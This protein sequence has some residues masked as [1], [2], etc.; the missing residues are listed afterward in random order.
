[1][2]EPITTVDPRI[3]G[4]EAPTGNAVP[5]FD[6]MG[7]APAL[8]QAAPAPDKVS[9]DLIG[10]GTQS[11]VVGQN[12][13]QQNARE[14]S[15]VGT[16]LMASVKT[17]SP[18]R[19]WDYVN[20]P[21]FDAD[22]DFDVKPYVNA[23]K[24]VMSED[25]QK[26]LAQSQSV[27]EFNYRQQ[28]TEQQR[29]LYQQMGDHPIL[30]TLTG[31]ADPGYLALDL[32]TMGVAGSAAGL[33]GAGR[34]AQR[35][36]AGVATA[37]TTYGLGRIQQDVV[38]MSE[39]DVILPALMTGAAGAMF[40]RAGKGLV[41]A[42]PDYPVEDLSR[43]TA[44]VQ[45]QNVGV[46][47]RIVAEQ[48][49]AAFTRP[50][51][52]E[53]PVA[54]VAEPAVAPEVI[55]N[56]GEP[57]TPTT[58]TPETVTPVVLPDDTVPVRRVVAGESSDAALARRGVTP[59][60]IA[61]GT[62]AY[63][64]LGQYEN[65]P[66]YGTM[67]RTL[68]QEQ[69]DLLSSLKAVESQ[70]LGDMDQAFY[71]HN[72]H[73]M[74]VGKGDGVKQPAF[75]ALHEAVHGLTAAKIEY[76][77]ANPGSAHGSLVQQL[78]RLRL[79]AKRAI[80]DTKGTLS[81]NEGYLQDYYTKN[82]H[83]FAAGLFSGTGPMGGG[84]VKALS[85]MSVDGAP[86]MLSR[87]TNTVRKL[88]G[89]PPNQQSVLT[90][91]LGLTDDL[92]NTKLDLQIHGEVPG[93]RRTIEPLSTINLAPKGTPSQQAATIINRQESAA[94]KVG[95]KISWSLHKTMAGLSSEGKRVADTLVDDPVNMT[96]DSVVS[97]KTAIRSDL[98]QK[99]YVYEDQLKAEMAKRGA[100]IKNRLIHP[101]N[102]AQI[103]RQVEREVYDELMRRNNVVRRGGNMNDP[104][105]NQ[106]IAKMA[107]AHDAATSAALREMKSAGVMGADVIDE[108]AGYTPR[109]WSVTQIESVEG[110]MQ[111]AGSTEKEARAQ[112]RKLV[113][114]A[115]SRANP[116]WEPQVV[117]DVSAAILD[118]ARRKGYFEDQALRGHAGD[119]AAKE[120]RDILT[121][122]G[123]SKDRIDKAL[124]VI[125]GVN[126]EAGK[127]A[128]LKHRIDMDTTTTTRLQDGTTASVTDLL[129]TNVARNL[130]GYLDNAA[131]NAALARKGLGDT[132]SIAKLRTD[133]LHGVSNEGKRKEAAGLFDN[134]IASIKG[135][136]VGEEMNDGM[137]KLA[138]VTQMVGLSSSG[139]WQVTEYANAMAKY[140]LLK[141]TREIMRTMPVF[142]QLM[143][144][145]RADGGAENLS[146]I[147]ARNSSQDLRIR[148]YIQKMEDNF[149]TDIGDHAMLLAQQAK[150]LVPY[151]NA[152][153][154][155]HH[156]Q[157]N[158]VGN[159]VAD[160]FHQ[161]ANGNASA[162]AALAKYGLEG[163]TLDS[164]AT[165]IKASGLDTS[166]W[167]D[168]T[169][170]QVRGPLG[171]MMDDAVLKNRTGEIPAF[172]QFSSL[173]KFIFTFRSFV[174]GAHNKVLAGSIGREG[175]GGI[176]L[177]MAYQFPLTMLATQA[178]TAIKGQ[179]PQD[180]K[181]TALMAVQQMG[182]MGLFGDLWGVASGQKQ[183]FGSSGLMAIDRLYKTG[184]AL[185][186]GNI[187]T[188]A[189]G[190][191][192]SIPLLSIVP[193]VKAFAETL[194]SDPKSNH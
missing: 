29:Q 12:T 16:S 121:S 73:T 175:F 4:G 184:S 55:L 112:T 113:G 128:T 18:V 163:H 141:T 99:Q 133:Y 62:D 187:G 166:G 118:R 65:D 111:A 23:T 156:N 90:K 7:S 10:A 8:D 147:L 83:E 140:G 188:A 192:N 131:G 179:P 105:V 35:I 178:N 53:P 33:L 139:L 74:Y 61:N 100:G 150:Q 84:F 123:A 72:T 122:S 161:G 168:A 177:L 169:W 24:F 88:L 101:V 103:Q 189:S 38:P 158:V 3:Y 27:D 117:H 138:A 1:M 116:D 110:R 165:D 49:D 46:E 94:E 47:Q 182:S 78:D 137:R 42:D 97:Q 36:A 15:S 48:S 26:F 148:P 109:K 95:Q 32:A 190:V 153:H 96:G 50:K 20:M 19:V 119:A 115:I 79:Q 154:Y 28:A 104:S 172:A 25:E 56:K 93:G 31:F 186:S 69:P 171:K 14:V 134:S 2:A 159:L 124:E 52:V 89:L 125:T 37:S 167:S 127:A 181:Q 21:H 191:V 82:L 40:Y 86:N 63:T 129:D 67:V 44:G 120:I 45:G 71:N 98:A 142:K 41:K 157:A 68:R 54:P 80:A 130:D 126:D 22:P 174:L 144:D 75:A 114:D 43:A 149:E 77:L 193:G 87:V 5:E 136:P 11:A 107:D 92:V 13:A 70:K 164:I 9:Q 145:P 162:R 64:H 91:A 173:G 34:T 66:L 176:G 132:S 185:A 143:G 85:K 135:Q 58:V 152:M 106:A 60:E 183:Q 30:S 59:D 108:S 160:L 51:V 146:K 17:W 81:K 57:V 6:P 180:L 102:S 170:N 194:K 155:I 39:A 151:I 76:G